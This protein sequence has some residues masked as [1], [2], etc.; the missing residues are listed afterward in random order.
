MCYSFF[1]R[2]FR[3]PPNKRQNYLKLSIAS[4]FKCPWLQLIQEWRKTPSTEFYYV[5]RDKTKLQKIQQ[6]LLGKERK[7]VD[8]DENCLIPVSL[9][10]NGRGNA[11][12]FSIICLPKKKDIQNREKN[13]KD[14]ENRPVL[15][16]PMA[17]DINETQ[18]K[19]M[20]LN[21]LKMLKRLRR[22]RVRV[23]RKQQ[24]F[25]NRKVIIL[26]SHTANQVKLQY[27][28]MCELW[29]PS[30]PKTIR[31]QCSREVFGYLTQCQFMFHEAKVSGVGYVTA[32]GI[33]QLVKLGVNQKHK[34][35][36]VLVRDP[37]SS[38]YRFATI[39]IRCH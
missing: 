39:S 3:R 34:S 30:E 23:K 33:R 9:V 1:C 2:Y 36:Q 27:D 22:R 8:V 7:L 31:H 14:F 6:F 12:K 16:E 19:L 24:E 17:T 32:N 10:M 18:R 38:N 11:Q 15:T 5:M 35:N 21:H 26:P 13:R 20:R 37:N 4:P 28:R 25:A 29:L